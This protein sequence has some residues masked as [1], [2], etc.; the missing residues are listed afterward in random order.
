[1]DQEIQKK[2]IHEKEVKVQEAVGRQQK[3]TTE[4]KIGAG[5]L[6]GIG[7]LFV[8]IGFVILVKNYMPPFVQGMLMFTF[9]A[10]VWLVSRLAV[11]RLSEKLSLGL[12]C[13]SILGLYLSVVVNYQSFETLPRYLALGILIL[14]GM[15]SWVDAFLS[16][17]ALISCM[18]FGGYLFFAL[19]LPWGKTIPEFAVM[20]V[21][22]LGL[23]LLWHLGAVGERKELVRVI[24]GSF[25]VLHTLFYG[26][27]LLFIQPEGGLTTVF[28][29][30]ILAVSLLNFF[31]SRNRNIGFFCIWLCGSIFQI[32]L[33]MGIFL[34]IEMTG[35][36]IEFL[37]LLIPAAVNLLLLIWKRFQWHWQGLFYQAVILVF[38]VAVEKP[39]WPG[40][41]ASLVLFGAGLLMIREKRLLHELIMSFYFYIYLAVQFDRPWIIPAQLAFLLVITV[42]CQCVPRLRSTKGA[43]LVYINISLMG[44][45]LLMLL[46]ERNQAN[47]ISNTVVLA[48]AVAAVL[49]LWRERFCLSGRLRGL[50]LVLVL[51][52]MVFIYQITLPVM[53]SILLMGVAVVSV[54]AGFIRRETALRIFGLCMA[55]FVCVK[56][57]VYDYWDLE[58]LPKSILLMAVGVIAIAISIVY[59][60]L[61]QKQKKMKIEEQQEG[62]KN[63]TVI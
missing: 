9:F 1:M 30:V 48:V 40:L 18:S 24:H 15:I 29:Y 17:S 26:I 21:I 53:V 44:L 55:L 49:I 31:Y 54:I 14:I 3:S 27:T 56:V 42:L 63:E 46:G 32:S 47:Y 34:G 39:M 51:S 10:V 36:E 52:Y 2:E 28:I 5:G 6:S 37:L 19:F 16:Q 62:E 12:S 38:L 59:A 8:L 20:A 43:P 33:L 45:S 58:L 4:F 7:I 11:V 60:V 41:A 57:I 50:M 61:E 13:A 35:G 25:F 23:N 22:M